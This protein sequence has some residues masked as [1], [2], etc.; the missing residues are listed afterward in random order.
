M[1]RA[2]RQHYLDASCAPATA[3]LN[4]NETRAFYDRDPD[5]LWITFARGRMWWA[6]AEP[7]VHWLGGSGEAEGTR[8][9]RTIDGWHDHDLA[10]NPLDLER[11]SSSLTQLASYRRMSCSVP[12]AAYCLRMIQAESDPLVTEPR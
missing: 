11:L 9:R 3:T 1:G 5:V 4:V 8:Y 7:E 10:G 2:V 12:E 6:F